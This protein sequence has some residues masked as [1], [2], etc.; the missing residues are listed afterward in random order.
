MFEELS[1]QAM[2]GRVLVL[3]GPP[4]S[5]KGVVARKASERGMSVLSLGDI[6]RSEMAS[7]GL[8]ETP[9]NVGKTALSM[10]EEHGEEIVV[11][12]LIPSLMSTL[13]VSDVLID[14]MRQPE[15][16]D[17]LK[18]HIDDVTVV[19]MSATPQSRS[20]WLEGR[21]RGE[22]GGGTE[23]TER[24]EREWG[25]GLEMLMD[26]A[27]AIILNEGSLEELEERSDMIF[28]TLGF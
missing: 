14:G 25:W 26:Q 18:K 21:G 9:A 5:G 4:G 17:R 7:K 10:R 13:E 20:E 16:M 28:E 2:T 8:P 3:C 23:F 12:R 1:P 27:H 15:E 19:A 6:V 11:D 24:E 22:D